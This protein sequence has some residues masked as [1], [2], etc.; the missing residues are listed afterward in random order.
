MLRWRLALTTLIVGVLLAGC[1]SEPAP[2]AADTAGAPAPAAA[3]VAAPQPTEPPL[4]TAPPAAGPVPAERIDL[5][6]STAPV[7][8]EPINPAAAAGPVP[9][10]RTDLAAS[11]APVRPEPINP[12]AAA[13]PVPAERIDQPERTDLTEFGPAGAGP[14]EAGSSARCTLAGTLHATSFRGIA[15]IATVMV[16]ETPLQ[17]VVGGSRTLPA[18]GSPVTISF[19]LQ[20]AVVPL[21]V[22]QRQPKP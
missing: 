1:D 18:A 19:D 6:A 16:N 21:T 14:G 10:E 22:A 15:S 11:T 12:A 7:R 8:P 4:P 2:P 5:T 13:G 3:T 20:Q 17:V 9:A